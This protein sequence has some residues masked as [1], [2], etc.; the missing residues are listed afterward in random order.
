MHS[1]FS[2]FRAHRILLTA[3]LICLLTPGLASSQHGAFDL[4]GKR[5][6]H[7]IRL[8]ARLSCWFFFAG[9]AQSPAVTRRL[10]KNQHAHERH[11]SFWLVFPDKADSPSDIRNYLREYGL[12]LAWPCAIPPRAGQTGPRANYAGGRGVQS[13]PSTYLRRKNRQLVCRSRPRPS[14]AHHS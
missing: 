13:Q 2:A 10:F 1:G 9:I 11:A 4:D 12:P 5:W 6:I 7:S 8:P 14:R 3:T